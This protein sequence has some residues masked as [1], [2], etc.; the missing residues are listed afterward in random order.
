MTQSGNIFLGPEDDVEAIARAL[1]DS[2]YHDELLVARSF[3]P[4][5][6][7]RLCAA[8][9][10]VMSETFPQSDPGEEPVTI[11]FPKMHLERS[12]LFDAELHVKKSVRR[13]IP[14]YELRFDTDFDRIVEK[15][16][17]VHGDG[18]LTKPLVD[19]LREM[20]DIKDL[21]AR[22]VSFGV[23]RN[24]E[25]KAGEFGVLVPK[26]EGN[27]GPFY[28]SYSGYYDEDNAG[29]VQMI[30]TSR[31]LAEKGFPFWDLG[32][33]LDYKTALGARI[34]TRE[35]FLERWFGI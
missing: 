17:S 25:L 4:Y 2:D 26:R 1:Y 9:F 12:V 10:L 30:L 21:P 14:R 13:F 5:F 6:I 23:Y 3:S 27:C 8:G 20:R 24:G 34:I 31:R 18:W 32:M 11:L 35:E 33:T 28:T 15:C 19:A 22:P 7:A 16:V 29:T